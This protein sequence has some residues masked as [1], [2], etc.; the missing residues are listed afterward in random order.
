V[1]QLA[2]SPSLVIVRLTTTVEKESEVM[3]IVVFKDIEKFYPSLEMMMKR[4]KKP[5]LRSK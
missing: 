2:P 5:R 3:V 1:A 4:V